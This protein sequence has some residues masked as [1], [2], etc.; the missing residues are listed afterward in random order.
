[1][2]KSKFEEIERLK[3]SK[4]SRSQRYMKPNISGSRRLKKSKIEVLETQP[5]SATQVESRGLL[6]WICPLGTHGLVYQVRPIKEVDRHKD[7]KIDLK[8]KKGKSNPY[9]T[10]ILVKS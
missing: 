4:I 7:S 3:K 8:T 9:L 6:T 2:K 1:L 10:R 5:E